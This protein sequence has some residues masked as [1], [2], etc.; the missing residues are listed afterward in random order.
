MKSEK[1]LFAVS[2]S[3]SPKR[4]ETIAVPPVPS[5]NPIAAKMAM[6]GYI[7]LTAEKADLPT[8]FDMKKPSTT[9]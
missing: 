4:R 8:K 7:R 2:L 3:P 9:V 6:K 5:I 1:Y